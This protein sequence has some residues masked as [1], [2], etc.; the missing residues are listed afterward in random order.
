MVGVQASR[1]T[2]SIHA[3]NFSNTRQRYHAK[4]STSICKLP[5]EEIERE[6]QKIFNKEQFQMEVSFKNGNQYLYVIFTSEQEQLRLI[7]CIEIQESVGNFYAESERDCTYKKPIEVVV[8]YIPAQAT[9]TDLKNVLE[10]E[11]GLATE[12][13]FWPIRGNNQYKKAK[14]MLEVTCSDKHLTETWSIQMGDNNR[15]KITPAR[16][17]QEDRNIRTRYV[18]TVMGLEKEVGIKE[19]HSLLIDLNAKEWYFNTR[20]DLVIYFQHGKDKDKATQEASGPFEGTIRQDDGIRDLDKINQEKDTTAETEA[21]NSM[22]DNKIEIKTEVP[23]LEMD[24]IMLTDILDKMGLEDT[25]NNNN[26]KTQADI[27]ETTKMDI[28]K[29]IIIQT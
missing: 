12:I 18:A 11:I 17:S 15:I 25:T 29:E 8:E 1:P 22:K 26:D 9:E 23:V 14:I 28:D 2:E 6:L 7:N 24:I 3:Y 10:N 5:K 4:I 13:T 21:T 19:V 27:I 16:L 20:H